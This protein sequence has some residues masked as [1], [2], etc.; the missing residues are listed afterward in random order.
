MADIYPMMAYSYYLNKGLPKHQAAVLAANSAHE[1][2]DSPTQLGDNGTAF[3]RFQWRGE[4]Q[5]GLKDYAK[6]NGLDPNADPTQWDYALHEMKTS[7]KDA[8][9]KFFKSTN[10]NEANDAALKFLRPAGY[11]PS[12]GNTSKVP[13]ATSRLQ[14]A[15][16]ISDMQPLP[17]SQYVG[18]GPNPMMQMADA[19]P[20]TAGD[21]DL[22]G[23]GGSP[24]LPDA[25]PY[26]F[27]PGMVQG[28]G[29]MAA[30]N[31]ST[32][33]HPG[34][35][36]TPILQAHVPTGDATLPNLL[37]KRKLGLLT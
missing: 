23:Y 8:G 14:M 5:A 34:L 3:G 21:A 2:P 18:S 29:I 22:A 26:N 35:S 20:R 27:N 25:Q 16:A 33:P 19:D 6:A 12:T 4:R 32:A 31:P 36:P 15:A 17:D 11:D 28:M 7:E 13:S 30:A 9:D 37:F 1:G 10:L 24:K